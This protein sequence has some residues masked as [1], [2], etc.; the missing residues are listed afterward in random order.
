MCRCLKPATRA[1]SAA[2]HNSIQ[3]GK[4]RANQKNMSSSA[5]GRSRPLGND[6]N[7]PEPW[8]LIR[9][10]FRAAGAGIQSSK[11]LP[12]H[13]RPQGMSDQGVRFGHQ[14][15]RSF[16]TVHLSFRRLLLKRKLADRSGT[17]RGQRQTPLGGCDQHQWYLSS[18]HACTSLATEAT[19][20]TPSRTRVPK[21]RCASGPVAERVVLISNILH[22]GSG[23]PAARR[24]R[25]WH[26]TKCHQLRANPE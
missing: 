12:I 11:P 2:R 18:I 7:L 5:M 23:C 24:A 15:S 1:G 22:S 19:L 13:Q 14:D 25:R 16:P 3:I 20:P 26:I 4:G 6:N 9:V 8:F 21:N 10:C 17:K